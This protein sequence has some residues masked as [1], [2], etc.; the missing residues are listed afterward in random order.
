[1]MTAARMGMPGSI[2]HHRALGRIGRALWL[3]VPAAA[4][5]TLAVTGVTSSVAA[6][7]ASP[8]SGTQGPGYP[9]P[10]GIYA[11][12]TNCPLSNPVMH[13]ATQFAACT[14]AFAVNG[15][16]TLG[17]ITTTVVAPLHV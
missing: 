11:P 1:M 2:G 13:E 9:P 12:F 6:A 10:K 7:P 14:G 5:L 15:S 16:I 3:G 4:A 17:T 8:S